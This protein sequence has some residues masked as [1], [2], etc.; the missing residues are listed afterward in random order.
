MNNF[1][2]FLN[3]KVDFGVGVS[4][5]IG[6]YCESLGCKS[7]MIV[8][9]ENLIKAGLISPISDQFKLKGIDF[10]IFSGV[11][12]N[13]T[14]EIIDQGASVLKEAACDMIIAIG[15]GSS[16]DTAKGMA[17]MA[18]NE[19]SCYDYLDG[20]SEDK[21]AITKEPIPIIALPTTS[22]TGSEVSMYS[23]ITDKDKIKDSITAA[24]IYP[25][26]A[27]VDPKLMVNL[28][29][30]PTAYTGLDVLGHAL[31]AYTSKIQNPMTNLWALEAMKL[32]FE[33][34]PSAVI[35]GDL[36]SRTQMAF[37]SLIAGSAMSH[38]GAT[39]PHALGCPLSG[40]Y[41]L[42]H[43]LTVGVLQIPMI[44]YNKVTL[45][46]EFQKIVKYIDPDCTISS[47]QAGNKLVLMI[48]ELF[49]K[50]GVSEVLT[51]LSVEDQ[52]MKA[53]VHDASIHGC[54][55]LNQKEISIEGIEEMFKLILK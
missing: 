19:G 51:N 23:V 43:G 24:S 4:D 6:E 39:L 41:D 3:T 26:V 54:L 42:P 11:K 1:Q 13:P 38:C 8:T 28:P 55:G 52:D 18:V 9:D 34:L 30:A 40:H 10:R 45:A 35:D 46:R 44:E 36:E 15:G 12:P 2:F 25:K 47:D 21:K 48:K 7:V 50:I 49:I 20:R 5:G 14:V 53:L 31:E 27:F 37:A 16:M 32:V 33:Y 29:K 17:V 22:G